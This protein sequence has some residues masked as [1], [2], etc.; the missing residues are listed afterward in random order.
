MYDGLV[1]V[2]G[3]ENG[4]GGWM[5][6]TL[7][8]VVTIRTLELL[9]VF[10]NVGPL[11]IMILQMGDDIVKFSVLCELTSYSVFP[12][13]DCRFI[14]RDAKVEANAGA[15]CVIGFALAIVPLA[16]DPLNPVTTPLRST[17]EHLLGIIGEQDMDAINEK[18]HT[19]GMYSLYLFAMQVILL[20]RD[21]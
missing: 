20:V 1:I 14:V 5:L 16:V 17:V 8:L 18:P 13:F 21:L 10:R 9:L 4:G 2:S 3:Q 19:M 11:V 12:P 15:F 6:S 7:I